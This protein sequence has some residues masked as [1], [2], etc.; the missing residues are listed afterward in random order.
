MF[1]FVLRSEEQCAAAPPSPGREL[2]ATSNLL[3]DSGGGNLG[4]DLL[5]LLLGLAVALLDLTE[6]N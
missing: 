3:G 6:K 4:L 5:L 1:I 2:T